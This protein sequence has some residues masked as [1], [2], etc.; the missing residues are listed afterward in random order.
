MTYRALGG[1]DVHG[2]RNRSSCGVAD[3]GV[4]IGPIDYLAEFVRI[5]PS[6]S[7]SNAHPGVEW[8]SRDIVVDTEEATIIGFAI[9]GDFKCVEIDAFHGCSH[10]D[11]RCI[12]AS[13]SRTHQPSW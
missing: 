2:G 11:H 9:D 7:D 3:W 10:S 4:T 5:N 13:K 8:S 1:F 12:T 6:R